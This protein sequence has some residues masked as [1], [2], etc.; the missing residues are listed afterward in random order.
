M[1]S[2][3]IAEQADAGQRV[4][5]NRVLL[6]LPESSLKVVAG[7]ASF[8]AGNADQSREPRKRSQ[9]V[10]NGA[11]EG[12]K[13]HKLA[14][15]INKRIFTRLKHSDIPLILKKVQAHIVYFK[16]SRCLK[17]SHY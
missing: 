6:L 2:L 7:V 15:K 16:E 12:H 5:E 11:P 14:I 17:K 1:F 8:F 10:E 4:L 13:Y 9:C 3:R